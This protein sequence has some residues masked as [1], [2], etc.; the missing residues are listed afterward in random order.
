MEA[1]E[2]G[3]IDRIPLIV[4]ANRDEQK[5][6][7]AETTGFPGTTQ[8]YQK[9]LLNSF[10]PL[11]SLVAAEYLISSYSAPLTLRQQPRPIAAFQ[12]ILDFVP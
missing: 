8:G 6:N 11:A 5:H 3:A 10:G 2:S 7:A 12:L 1:I 4:G 9:Y